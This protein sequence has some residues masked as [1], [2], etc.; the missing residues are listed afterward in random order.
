MITVFMYVVVDTAECCDI[1]HYRT[2]FCKAMFTSGAKGI[3]VVECLT[4]DKGAAGSSLTGVTALWSLSK[5][6]L[7]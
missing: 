2:I 7:S 3:S 1:P 6:H 4:R 5:T